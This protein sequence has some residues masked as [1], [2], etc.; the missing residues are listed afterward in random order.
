[1]ADKV[2]QQ[3]V[4]HSGARHA[5][6][7]FHTGFGIRIRPHTSAKPEDAHSVEVHSTCPYV[8]IKKIQEWHTH[9]TILIVSILDACVLD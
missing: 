4:S 9:V 6:A 3:V 5:E 1:M 2:P 8:H 7:L